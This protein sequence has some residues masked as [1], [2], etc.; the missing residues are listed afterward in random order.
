M[1][2]CADNLAGPPLVGTAA[3][4]RDRASQAAFSVNLLTTHP[5]NSENQSRRFPTAMKRY[6][7]TRSFY[8]CVKITD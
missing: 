3:S 5:K 7:K 6:T 1:T 8:T 4:A 2:K